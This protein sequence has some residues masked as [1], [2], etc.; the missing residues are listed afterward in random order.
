MAR[1]QGLLVSTFGANVSEI[2]PGLRSLP[3]DHLILVVEQQRTRAQPRLS[4]IGWG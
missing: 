3:H 1:Q 2:V 4:W